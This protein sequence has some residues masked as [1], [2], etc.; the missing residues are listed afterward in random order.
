V[1]QDPEKL[2][3]WHDEY[4]LSIGLGEAGPCP[5]GLVAALAPHMSY[6]QRDRARWHERRDP[7][8]GEVRKFVFR[9]VDLYA[10]EGDPPRLACQ[11]GYLAR[12]VETAARMGYEVD[13]RDVKF[14]AYPD[15]RPEAFEP[16]WGRYAE[17]FQARERQDEAVAAIYDAPYGR[18]DAAA[19]F[20]K[21]F[22][23]AGL[24]LLFPKAEIVV[25]EPTGRTA[26]TA[27]SHFHKVL[28]ASEVGLVGDG[29]KR[30]ARV[31]IFVINSLALHAMD[32]RPDFLVVDECHAAVSDK[33]AEGVAT[34]G[35]RA[36][37]YGLSA[38]MQDRG[39][40]K[41]M[42]LE[43]L[44]GPVVFGMSA[45]EAT[46]LGLVV[47]IKVVWHDVR[48]HPNPVDGVEDDVERKRLG[49]WFN[50]PRNDLIASIARGYPAGERVLILVE[51]TA[52]ALELARRLPDF[53]VCVG[54]VSEGLDRSVLGAGLV[55]PAR[56]HRTPR[57]QD[58]LTKAFAAGT[59]P[60][61]I[62]TDTLGVGF[63]PDACRVMIR[64]DARPSGVKGIQ[65][66][67]RVSRLHEPSGKTHGVVH[68]FLD[69][70]D[71]GVNNWAIRRRRLYHRLGYEQL[72]ADGTPVVVR[73]SA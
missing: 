46:G 45:A 6:V 68:E 62:G 36:R 70:F 64:A 28:P 53:Q 12:V 48:T 2:V 13:V 14:T 54:T 57:E 27:E 10:L 56:V 40:N 20:G 17:G 60:K 30:K 69:Q 65:A 43:G 61:L 59:S 18:V 42:R 4:T 8:T 15:C 29:S 21:T 49:V 22:L 58:R 1:N 34:A 33:F 47:P 3:V 16:D 38:S 24:G 72:R 19:G 37:M 55:D 44:L 51:T 50:A 39:D 41:H 31:T 23:A 25:C 7:V 9:P 63:S 71:S 66:P 73:T 26:R 52:H 67:G 32:V 35:R 11:P 5:P